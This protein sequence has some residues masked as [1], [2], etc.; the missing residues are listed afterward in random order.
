MAWLFGLQAVPRV[1]PMCTNR[2]RAYRLEAW[3]VAAVL[4]P[5]VGSKPREAM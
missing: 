3:L 1:C 4:T 2:E 5:E